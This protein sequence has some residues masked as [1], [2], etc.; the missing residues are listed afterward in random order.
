MEACHRCFFVSLQI[1][2]VDIKV[3]FNDAAFPFY[4]LTLKEFV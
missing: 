3:A 2:K 1:G 4:L